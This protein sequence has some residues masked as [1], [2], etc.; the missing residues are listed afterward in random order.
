[1]AEVSCMCML[2]ELHT[3]S[4]IGTILM[5]LDSKAF[6]YRKELK[7]HHLPREKLL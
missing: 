5:T 3:Q 1:M 4:K 6:V 7:V 2:E